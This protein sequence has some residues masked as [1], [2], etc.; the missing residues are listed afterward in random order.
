MRRDK[1]VSVEE[2]RHELP[3]VRSVF[4]LLVFFFYIAVI[5]L[6]GDRWICVAFLVCVACC[7]SVILYTCIFDKR[8]IRNIRRSLCPKCNILILIIS[9]LIFWFVALAWC[10]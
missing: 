2:K 9:I 3:I 6:G 1:K 10:R 8:F 7:T 4:L 5:K